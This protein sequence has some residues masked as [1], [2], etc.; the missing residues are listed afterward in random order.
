MSQVGSLTVLYLEVNLLV[1]AKGFVAKSTSD[2][3]LARWRTNRGWR[4]A[5]SSCSKADWERRQLTDYLD[6][7]A[8]SHK[9]Q[10]RAIGVIEHPIGINMAGSSTPFASGGPPIVWGTRTNFSSLIP[11]SLD[12]VGGHLVAA[13]SNLGVLLRLVGHTQ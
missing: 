12:P 8:D 6:I 9:N 10:T 2:S 5:A 11:S 1:R 13:R 3:A 7:A 4:S